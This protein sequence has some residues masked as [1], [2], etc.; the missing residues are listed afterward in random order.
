[1]EKRYPGVHF[2]KRTGK[3]TATLYYEGKTHCLGTYEDE[4]TAMKVRD[5]VIREKGTG[6]KRY[7]QDHEL[8][9][10]IRQ[11]YEEF[12]KRRQGQQIAKRRRFGKKKREMSRFRKKMLE[13]Q[14]L[15]QL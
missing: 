15:A 12:L 14:K 5:F 10:K 7:F 4:L 6:H 9:F 8:G 3:W 2:Y 1:M 11:L 13:I